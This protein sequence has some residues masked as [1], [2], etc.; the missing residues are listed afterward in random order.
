MKAETTETG[1]ANFVQ[2]AFDIISVSILIYFRTISTR[3]SYSG[4]EMAKNSLSRI[5]SS[6]KKLYY[7]DILDTKISIVS[8]DS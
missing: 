2:K 7:L 8:S 3:R 4:Q 1:V 5:L 6:S